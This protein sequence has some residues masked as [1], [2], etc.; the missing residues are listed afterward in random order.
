MKISDILQ[1][2]MVISD[3]QAT[4]KEALLQEMAEPPRER[5]GKPGAP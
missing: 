3:L 1:E 2:P 5:Q 4:D